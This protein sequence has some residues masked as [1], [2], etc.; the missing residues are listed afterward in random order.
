M[1]QEP[2]F[3]RHTGE[4]SIQIPAL[5]RPTIEQINEAFPEMRFEQIE[6]DTAPTKA[7]TLALA[8]VLPISETRAISGTE[9]EQ[10]IAPRRNV[11]LG[12]QQAVWLV[13][14]QDEF[15]EFMALLGKIYINFSG[16]VVKRADDRHYI[17]CLNRF[18]KRW[19]I[20]WNWLDYDFDSEGRIAS[21]GKVAP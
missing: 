18:G 12:Y 19:Y 21:S 14:H 3:F 16:L 11:I 15:P 5:Q 7:L 17:P 9:Y 2:E 4:L 13:E 1:P 10:R 6:R 8:T 20:Y